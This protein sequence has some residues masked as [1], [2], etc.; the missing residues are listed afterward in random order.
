[1]I[2]QG[3]RLVRLLGTRKPSEQEL[4]TLEPEDFAWEGL[5]EK[6]SLGFAGA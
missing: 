5:A 2:A 4:V 1:M 6:P 3:A